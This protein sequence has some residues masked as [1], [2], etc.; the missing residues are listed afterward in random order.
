MSRAHEPQRP[1]APAVWFV[2]F[3]PPRPFVD[4]SVVETTKQ[5]TVDKI[6]RSV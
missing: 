5:A 4:Y 6:C 1:F 3:D 2:S